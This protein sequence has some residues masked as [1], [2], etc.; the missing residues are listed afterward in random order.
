[1]TQ[2]NTTVNV[3]DEEELGASD[4]VITYK[5]EGENAENSN[6]NVSNE[7]N[8]LKNTLITES[9]GT[10]T[11]PNVSAEKLDGFSKRQA[12]KQDG[13]KQE[14]SYFPYLFPYHNLTK[15]PHFPPTIGLNMY[16][17][18]HDPVLQEMDKGGAL[19]RP[20]TL[21]RPLYS[22]GLLSP[23]HLFPSF[24]IPSWKNPPISL[25]A[26][27]LSPYSLAMRT[28][29]INSALLSPAPSS[30]LTRPHTV[31]SLATS[32]NQSVSSISSLGSSPDYQKNGDVRK[33]YVKKPLNAFMLFMRENREKV[34]QESTLKE[35]AAINQILGRKWH[36]LERSEQEKY[37]EMARKERQVHMSRFPDWTAR[38]NYANGKKKKRKRVANKETFD[39][40]A[41]VSKKCR[42]RFGMDQQNNW[43]KHCRRKKKCIMFREPGDEDE[44]ESSPEEHIPSPQQQQL[45]QQLQQHQQ[46]HTA[47]VSVAPPAVE[48]ME[49]STA[50]PAEVHPQQ[51]PP[52]PAP[53]D[54][55]MES[56]S[57]STIDRSCLVSRPS[58]FTPPTFPFP[59]FQ[60]HG[61]NPLQFVPSLPPPPTGLFSSLPSLSMS[62][63]AGFDYKNLPRSP[64]PP[65]RSPPQN[66]SLKVA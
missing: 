12:A 34:I 52:P 46:Q 10:E 23:S 65:P 55:S 59:N 39:S 27:Q 60:H 28:S 14:S 29:Q 48:A 25:A 51:P 64:A 43:C 24:D 19:P 33:P 44:E 21:D 36:Q 20:P 13:L 2:I 30:L 16:G 9:E 56:K 61:F 32:S 37:Y 54:L 18:Q 63:I 49:T 45:Q 3:D 38:D 8:D 57:L 5:D 4:E 26:V 6:G 41:N 22:P 66:Q 7:I 50:Q 40:D 1:M 42:A 58:T 11:V 15:I 62:S 17:L 47:S 35:S 53:V 31:S